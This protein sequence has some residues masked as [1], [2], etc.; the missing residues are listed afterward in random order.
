MIGCCT[1]GNGIWNC[2]KA[3]T[4][5]AVNFSRRPLVHGPRIYVN[6]SLG[7]VTTSSYGSSTTC[8]ILHQCRAV[9]CIDQMISTVWPCWVD[10]L[11]TVSAVICCAVNR[12]AVGF[13]RTLCRLE[14]I[15]YSEPYIQAEDRKSNST[16]FHMYE[17]NAPKWKMKRRVAL[18]F[19]TER[20]HMDNVQSS[21]Y[22]FCNNG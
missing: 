14:L 4:R 10:W 15:P 7:S 3:T 12:T 5:K 2:K 13:I 18:P 8:Y 22:V 6:R 16:A 1:Q 11:R 21:E 9:W 20:V 17:I 19:T